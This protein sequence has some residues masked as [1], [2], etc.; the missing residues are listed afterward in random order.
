[1]WFES[2]SY[3]HLHLNVVAHGSMASAHSL[4]S[5]FEEKYTNVISSLAHQ[6]KQEVQQ[7]FLLGFS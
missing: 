1:M 6:P 7:Q 2:L 3:V 4:Y 5:L